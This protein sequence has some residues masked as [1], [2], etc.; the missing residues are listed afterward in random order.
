MATFKVGQR[1]RVINP[2]RG[3]ESMSG[4]QGIVTSTDPSNFV[5]SLK[6]PYD[7]G[8][9]LDRAV[10][11][12][13]GPSASFKFYAWELAPLTDP[14]ADAFIEKLKKLGSEPLPL[15]PAELDR[16]MAQDRRC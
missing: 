6:P 10:E 13:T 1:V 4:L 16:I 12:F 9:T 3:W 2:E 14:K 15:T 11:T 7:Y 5:R 8:V